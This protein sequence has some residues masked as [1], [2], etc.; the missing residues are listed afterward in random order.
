VRRKT[1][2]ALSDIIT[3]HLSLFQ[4]SRLLA[5]RLDIELVEVRNERIR[6][7]LGNIDVRGLEFA[8]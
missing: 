6:I 1:S 8:P 4:F 5:E 3:I 2:A 7:E